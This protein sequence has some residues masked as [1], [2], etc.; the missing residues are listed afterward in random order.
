MNHIPIIGLSK[1]EEIKLKSIDLLLVTTIHG[2]QNIAK[3]SH[4]PVKIIWFFCLMISS[5]YCAYLMSISFINFFE[6]DVITN[7]NTIYE[8]QSE[9]PAVSFCSLYGP[10]NSTSILKCQF[11]LIDCS[12]YIETFNGSSLGKCFRFNSG[13]NKYN[14]KVDILKTK[15]LGPK[16]GLILDFNI[17]LYDGNDFNEL[18]VYIHN[19]TLKPLVFNNRGI[20]VTT[21]SINNFEIQKTLNLKLEA[22]YN[23]CYKDVNEFCYNKTIINFL[24]DSNN[25]YLRSDCIR[26]SR[27]MK[28]LEQ[29]NCNCINPI[30]YS[31][32]CMDTDICYN[33]FI[34][35]FQN[36]N[37]DEIFSNYCP[38]EC[39]TNSIDISMMNSEQ[40]PCSGN[41]SNKN[42]NFD[43][44][45]VFENYE[46][47]Q[48]RFVSVKIYFNEM[49][50]TFISQKPKTEVVDL[51][52]NMGGTMGLFL[53]VSFLSFVEIFE[54]FTEISLILFKC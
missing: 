13:T 25:T 14:Q 1:N 15:I 50:Y 39:E 3:S 17:H 28:F 47:V 18:L 52:S 40:L 24:H 49:K 44:K 6:Y 35:E 21:G 53:G 27:N 51:V 36:K 7:I 42:K 26:L 38:Y 34:T 45:N 29:T 32:N 46:Q 19:Q 9:F 41:I 20:R 16:F 5:G 37:V 54:F 4:A 31:N 12:L 33:T 23:D 30:D 2:I 43:Y 48:K 11:N 8:Q 22:P 10:L